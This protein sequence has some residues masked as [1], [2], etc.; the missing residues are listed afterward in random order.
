MRS[1]NWDNSLC[2]RLKINKRKYSETSTANDEEDGDGDEYFPLSGVPADAFVPEFR[3]VVTMVT[4][5][6]CGGDHDGEMGVLSVGW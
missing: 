1:M 4:M 5:A 2:Q 3:F 6:M